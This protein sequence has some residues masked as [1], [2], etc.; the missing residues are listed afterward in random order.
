MLSTRIKCR[1]RVVKHQNAGVGHERTSESESLALPARQC[2]ALLA[3]NRVVPIGKF[4]DEL[5]CLGCTGS[6][7]DVIER[8]FGPRETEVVFHRRREQKGILEHHRHGRPQRCECQVFHI[9]AVDHHRA[10]VQVDEPSKRHRH[11]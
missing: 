10:A 8:R 11:G 5:V 2:E 6:G 1:R 7:N 9:V 3:D 4:H